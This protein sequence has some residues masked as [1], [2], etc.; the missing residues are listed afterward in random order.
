[1]FSTTNTQSRSKPTGWDGDSINELIINCQS[2]SLCSKPTAWDGDGGR[3]KRTFSGTRTVL[4][5]PRGMVTVARF[6][7]LPSVLVG[8]GSKP[9]VWDGDSQF[10]LLI[11]PTFTMFQAHCVGW[12]PHLSHRK[13]CKTQHCSEPTVW[14]GDISKGEH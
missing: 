4:S 2:E 6:L 12:R 3:K 9:T 8:Q 14:D 1:M 5:P 10:F 13:P 7:L 11:S